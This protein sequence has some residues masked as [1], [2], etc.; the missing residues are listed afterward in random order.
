MY[1]T[2]K[3]TKDIVDV[4]WCKSLGDDNFHLEKLV[5]TTEYIF[6]DDPHCPEHLKLTPIPKAAWENVIYELV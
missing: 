2:D 6:N 1:K 5:R 3:V 4:R